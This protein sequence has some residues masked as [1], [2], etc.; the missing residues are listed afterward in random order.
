MRHSGRAREL[1]RRLLDGGA[2]HPEHY[3]GS[4]KEAPRNPARDAEATCARMVE[5]LVV[6]LG[7]RGLC[8]LVRRALVLSAPAHPCLRTATIDEVGRVSGIREP[9][10]GSLEETYRGALALLDT[11]LDL[12]IT[13][14]GEDLTLR[15]VQEAF[16][17]LSLGVGMEAEDTD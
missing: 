3:E 11:L 16:P 10:E 6:L 8:A 7:P 5:Q 15:F 9:A 13:F 1:A 2:T 4:E 17:E 12:L 14:I